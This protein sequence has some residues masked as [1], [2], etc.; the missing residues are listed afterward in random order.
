MKRKKEIK[1]KGIGVYPSITVGSVKTIFSGLFEIPKVNVLK[2]YV[3][4]EIKRFQKALESSK[5]QILG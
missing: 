4:D 5:N 3:T 1:L 2:S